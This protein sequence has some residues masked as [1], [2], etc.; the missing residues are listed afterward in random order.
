[1]KKRFT[2]LGGSPE[3][4]SGPDQLGLEDGAEV[5]RDYMADGEWGWP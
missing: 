3:A 1:M 4:G 2:Q 5:V